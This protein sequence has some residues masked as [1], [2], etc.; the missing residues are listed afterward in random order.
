[1]LKRSKKALFKLK[2]SILILKSKINNCFIVC[3][4]IKVLNLSSFHFFQGY[5]IIISNVA[6]NWNW[7]RS[8]VFCKSAQPHL[9]PEELPQ[10]RSAEMATKPDQSIDG[11]FDFFS[12][13][14]LFHVFFQFLWKYSVRKSRFINYFLLF[15]FSEASL[16]QKFSVFSID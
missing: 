16:A 15:I 9:Q 1:M 8:P 13:P 10:Q 7:R 6:E 2:K 5:D 4:S 11:K 3:K 14:R 12:K